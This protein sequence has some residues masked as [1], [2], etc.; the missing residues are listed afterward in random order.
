MKKLLVLGSDYGT[1]DIVN[2]AHKMGIYVIV[3]DLMQTSPTKE[4]ADEAWMI[5]TT[6]IDLLAEKCK[7]HN[8]DGVLTGASDFN[9][10]RS[11][12]LCE[13]LGFP[14]YC[15]SDRAWEVATNK[16][17]FKELCKK[18]G[19]PVAQDY[20]LTDELSESDLSKIKYP[21]VV[22]PVD[23]SGNRGMSYCSTKEELIK[24][25]KYAR[26]VS[27][28]A[29]IIVER[30]L[31]GPEFAVNYVMA[32]G[33]INLYFFSSEHNQPGELENLYSVI[34]TT[35]E[36]LKLYLDEVNDKV[37]EVFKEAGCKD[38]VAWVECIYD[39][40]GHFY[41]LEMG[42]R[43]GGEVVNVPYEKV[44]GFNS[45]RFMI[46]YALGIKHTESDLPAKLEKA[47]KKCAATY[48]LFA[49]QDGIISSIEGL[50]EIIKLPN[51]TLDMPKRVGGNVRYHATMGNLHINANDIEDLCKTIAQINDKLKI[52]DAEG[53]DLFI[54]FD[55][56][57]ALRKEYYAGLKE[58]NLN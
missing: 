51:V 30:E 56:Y 50:D 53:K 5:S 13:K 38:G 19:A 31:H 1:I 55:D 9:I 47:E 32:D 3:T 48:L 35:G 18:I 12:E 22:K 40:D 58:F 41:L 4:A 46:E 42:Y 54:Y 28:N 25:Y 23:K 24:A 16:R 43:F 8:I 7:E 10:E 6:E 20:Y 27:E 15:Q 45:M 21:V 37:I 44:S 26:S 33:N 17:E 49:K 39:D 34:V 52:T 14:V 2:E 29:A 57:D 36:H 11:R